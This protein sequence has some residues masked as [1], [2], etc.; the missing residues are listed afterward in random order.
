MDYKD[1]FILRVR[2]TIF[3]TMRH[4]T[5][6]QGKKNTPTNK[7]NSTHQSSVYRDSLRLPCITSKDFEGEV[8]DMT[9]KL[10]GT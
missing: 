6:N 4:L 7:G 10:D 1:L 2:P 9:L 3:M 8:T 5:F